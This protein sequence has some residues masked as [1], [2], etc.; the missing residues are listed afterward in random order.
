VG[1]DGLPEPVPDED[2]MARAQVG[3]SGA[4]GE[5]YARYREPISRYV[6]RILRDRETA[7][8]VTQEAFCRAFDAR[9]S[10][11]P[12]G[13][14]SAWLYAI[15]HNLCVNE[16]RRRKARPNVSL[17]TTVRIALSDEDS[18]DVELHE[19]IADSGESVEQRLERREVQGLIERATRQLPDRQRQIVA[20]RFHQGMKYAE[21]RE[22]IG[23]SIGTIKSRIHHAVRRIRRIIDKME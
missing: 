14:F 21:I 8:D 1:R 13:R 18:E 5:L 20:L 19:M 10:F 16:F 7:D 9:A 11:D 22:Q 4:F 12:K 3:D 6:N 23:C 15:A 17:N 2:L